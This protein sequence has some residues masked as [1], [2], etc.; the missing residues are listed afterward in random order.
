MKKLTALLLSKTLLISVGV[1]GLIVGGGFVFYDLTKSGVIPNYT[2]ASFLEPQKAHPNTPG[3]DEITID[4]ETTCRNTNIKMKPVIYLYPTK[5]QP[6]SVKLHYGGGLA[7]TYPEYNNGWN[8]VASPNGTLVNRT[9]GKEYSYLFWE[10]NYNNETYDMSQGFVVKGSETQTFL[11]TNLAKLGLTPKE[12]N[13]FI[14]FWLPRMKDNAYN[15]IHFASAKEYDQKAVL[16][17]TPKPD[18]IRRIFMVYKK[19]DRNMSVT[20]QHITPFS[21][22]GFTVIEWGGTEI[23]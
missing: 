16:D 20:P 14:V 11:Q 22:N 10:G 15:L 13:E 4:G 5:T 3:C 6:V 19:I 17:I 12:Y 8:V 2:K 21:R 1:S 7:V 18:S 9:D 23:K